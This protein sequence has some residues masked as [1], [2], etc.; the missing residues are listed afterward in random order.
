MSFAKRIRETLPPPFRPLVPE[1]KE[2]DLPDFKYADDQTPYAKEGQEVLHLLKNK[3]TEDEIQ[4]VLDTVHEQAAALGVADVLIPS[5]DIY[6]SA[7]LSV[8]SKS[9]SHVLSTIDRCKERLAAV[10]PQSEAARRQV[11]SAVMD[12]WVDHPGNAVNIVDKLLN[13]GIIVPMTV[14]EWALQ[15]HIDRGRALASGPVYELVA[16]TM[17]KVTA[18][19]REI[20]TQRNSPSVPYESRQQIDE[21]L[22]RERQ[23]ARDMYTAIDEAVGAVAAGIQDDMIERYDDGANERDLITLWGKR[24]AIVWRRKSAVEEAVVGE[25]AIGPLEEPPA[26]VEPEAPAQELGMDVADEIV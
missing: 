8:G 2:K 12:F 25:Q 17:A 13:Y 1:R 19:L 11:I 6:M 5:T 21:M 14:I 23:S 7:I 22:P 24:W 10:G 18:R 4:K 9:L 20:V 15:D 26:P 16:S 3:G